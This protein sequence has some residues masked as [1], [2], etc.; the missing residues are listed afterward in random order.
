M[1]R[2]LS[3]TQAEHGCGLVQLLADRLTI[4][5][6]LAESWVGHGAVYVDGKRCRDATSTVRAG[7]RLI[8]YESEGTRRTVALVVL[9]QDHDVAFVDKPAGLPTLAPRRGGDCLAQQVAEYFGS[10]ARLM[11]RLDQEASGVLLVS[12][13][14][15]TRPWLQQQVQA[16]LGR[17]YLAVVNGM[18]SASSFSINA[19]L[20]KR[21]ATAQVGEAAAAKPAITGVK[22]L[23]R[24]ASHTL[25]GVTPQ[26]GRFH[27]IRAHLAHV[28]LP[29]LGDTRYGGVPH[30]R[31][32]LHA[33]C[34][35][36]QHPDGRPVE[37]RSKPG[38]GIFAELLETQE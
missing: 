18:P 27:Q 25:L 37:A 3:V 2:I 24:I 29:L 10:S 38:D 17:Y 21:G 19:P 4:S 9:H 6:T 22:V 31:L 26:T 12:L 28:G 15:S 11:H 16:H 33:E 32:A 20:S 13:R 1:K 23:K 7:Q 35:R 34:I 5:L 8:V 14:S 36:L 30:E